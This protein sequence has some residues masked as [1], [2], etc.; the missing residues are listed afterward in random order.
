MLKRLVLVTGVLLLFGTC[1]FATTTDLALAPELRNEGLR[2]NL[3]RDRFPITDLPKEKSIG[4]KVRGLHGPFVRND[5]LVK[6][7]SVKYLANTPMGHVFVEDDGVT[8][9]L[10]GEK[11]E[12]KKGWVIKERLWQTR[13]TRVEG[14]RLADAKVN[15]FKGKDPEEWKTGILTY[16]ELGFGEICENTTL[17]LRAKGKNIEKIFMI[18]EGGNP[19]TIKIEIAGAKDLKINDR[20][21]L[22]IETGIGT[23]KMTK[24]FAYQDIDGKRVEVAADYI[25][26]PP[27]ILS[28][29]EGQRE[30]IPEHRTRKP[31]PTYGFR[32]GDYN[33][34]H[35]LII[36]PLLAST[37]IGGDWADIVTGIATD[38]S[39]N[40]YITGYTAPSYSNPQIN[41]PTTPGAY[42]PTHSNINYDAFV[43]KFNPSLSTLLASTFL[44]GNG[45]DRSYAMKIDTGGNVFVAGYT[46]S[47][48]FP[49]SSNAYMRTYERVDAFIAK[50]S[51]DLS[52]LSASTYLRANDAYWA[53]EWLNALAID[54]S[55]NVYAAG[56]SD[57]YGT[58]PAGGYKT[59]RGELSV[60][61]I[62]VKLNSDLSTLLG[63]TFLGG[64]N[65][66]DIAVAIA[67]DSSGNVFVT[68]ETNYYSEEG[69]YKN[70]FPVTQGAYAAT[71]GTNY[72]GCVPSY[73]AKLNSSLSSLLAATYV[74]GP[75]TSGC[76]TTTSYGHTYTES[77]AVGS[78]GNVYVTGTTD[79][80]TY[81]TTEWAYDR[82]FSHGSGCYNCIESFISKMDNDLSSLVASTYI[83]GNGYDYV[84][85]MA[86]DHTGNVY[87]AGYTSSQDYPTTPGADSTEFGGWH[88]G[89]VSKLDP[90][91]ARLIYSS[92]LG[93]RND[94]DE[95]KAITLVPEG[96]IVVSGE[97]FSSDFPVTQGSYRTTLIGNRDLFVTKIEEPEGLLVDVISPKNV[98]PGQEVT[99]LVRYMNRLGL[100][101]EN[102]VVTFDIPREFDLSSS[103]GNGIY[104]N[105]GNKHEVFWKL[106]NLQN[107]SGG[108]L[109]VKVKSPGVCPIAS[110]L[111]FG[112][113]RSPKGVNTSRIE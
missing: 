71:Y 47:D 2:S 76:G 90:N 109:A 45:D 108:E 73:I 12:D 100:I 35:P 36:D 112:R 25:I 59:T 16:E 103:T 34:K 91:L 7:D 110:G 84:T 67:L 57:N 13:P 81:P 27:S 33:R 87:I 37:F 38:A 43:A 32:V 15:Y 9:V 5:Q 23:L 10:F 65:V 63:A 41:F 62:I 101:A 8:Y 31:E 94:Y 85:S 92:F 60:D 56:V 3:T 48:N 44:G 11:G 39:G 96:K 54:S 78:S 89:F 95:I 42:D 49:T 64:E 20:G 83:G 74:G 105:D 107:E 55:G 104:R 51:S 69:T 28:N 82:T 40:I 99:F 52:Q 79:T 68:G 113:N 26:N 77:I 29:K 106:G 24:P 66:G 97:T 46:N 80:G 18:H 75:G 88:D 30:L 14:T 86:L 61:A 58:L 4:A 1:A 21:D 50:F 17:T 53:G 6:K 19:E 98:T 70:D 22:E 93:G 72:V 102:V 111:S